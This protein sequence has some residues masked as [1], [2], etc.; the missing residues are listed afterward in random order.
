MKRLN[1]YVAT[2][3]ANADSSSFSAYCIVAAFGTYFCM[4]AFRKPFTAGTFETVTF[5]GMAFKPILIAAQVAGYTLSKFLGIK[6]VSEMPPSR[7]ALGIVVLIGIAELA[8]LLFAITP[9]PYNFVMLFFNGLPLG[10]VFGFVLAFLEGRR[11]TEALAAGLCA[12]FIVASGVVKSVGRY[13]IEVVGVSEF[14]MPFVTGLLF[15][16]PLLIFVWMLHH[17]PAPSGEDVEHRSERVPMN[18]QQR[19]DFFNRHA[20]GLIGLISIYILLTVMRSIRDD[21]AVEIWRDLGE[22]QE[23]SVFARSEMLVMLGVVVVN[24]AA[25]TIHSNRRAFLSA[26]VL[27][28]SG[29][30]V[31][32]STLYAHWNNWLSSFPFMVLAGLGMYVP[33]VAFHTTLFE[34]LIAVF[35]ERG[36][37]GYLMYL[38]DATG[39]LAYVALIICKSLLPQDINFLQLFL[40]SSLL[41]AV[42]SAIIT[43]ALVAYYYRRIPREEVPHLAYETD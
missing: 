10:M 7:R 30:V 42:L 23:P 38:A 13:L 34:R 24:G 32:L 26:L 18:R 22:A 8:L 20:F 37:I 3:L 35:R 14:W 15:V 29:F 17:I 4:Y 25:I 43:V 12:S 21:F 2:R 1:Q 6:F 39:Y 5:A 9:A 40:T 27:V 36:N 33:Y 19:R 28:A 16:G 11:M 31:I 41:M